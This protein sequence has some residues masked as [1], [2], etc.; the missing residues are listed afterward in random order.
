MSADGAG[1][2]TES[3]AG[4][5]PERGAG[6]PS[7][8]AQSATPTRSYGWR[9]TNEKFLQII[10]PPLPAPP[11]PAERLAGRNPWQLSSAM[12][13]HGNES[14]SSH[15]RAGGGAAPVPR[16]CRAPRVRT[17]KIK[18]TACSLHFS[19]P[20]WWSETPHHARL[21]VPGRGGAGRG[22]TRR[23]FQRA[24]RGG[25]PGYRTPLSLRL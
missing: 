19:H 18:R 12:A 7:G 14:S 15:A 1:R 2:G 3:W 20:R 25:G 8:P 17:V 6:R 23:R 22:L 16:Q 5:A 13:W 24:G 4:V 11:A 21:M 9:L 10:T